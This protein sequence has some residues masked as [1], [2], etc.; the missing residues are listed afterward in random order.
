MWNVACNWCFNAIILQLSGIRVCVCCEDKGSSTSQFQLVVCNNAYAYM[1]RRFRSLSNMQNLE[2]KKAIPF[3][4]RIVSRGS[5]SV[6][7]AFLDLWRKHTWIDKNKQFTQAML[8]LLTLLA[9]RD[10]TVRRK[11][12]SPNKPI[13]H[14][15][16]P[17]VSPVIYP[18]TGHPRGGQLANSVAAG[19]WQWTTKYHYYI[20]KYNVH[21]VGTIWWDTNCAGLDMIVHS[22]E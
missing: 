14:H 10:R 8:C 5:L 6:Y 22:T 15:A 12:L 3:F 21:I 17:S 16:G 4:R 7:P 11:Q 13:A 20:K 2:E 19:N 9:M 18:F 1:A